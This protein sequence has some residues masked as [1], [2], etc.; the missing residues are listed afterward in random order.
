[1]LLQLDESLD[2]RHLGTFPLAFYAAQRWVEYAMYEDVASRFKVHI[3]QLFN[4]S[5]P[6]L[7]A[8]TWMHDVDSD[9]VRETIDALE[10]RPMRP[11]AA[12]LYYAVLC[13]FSGLANYLIITHG[14]DVNA[15]CGYHGSSLHAASYMGHLDYARLLLA[16]GTDVNTTNKR[17]KTP[18]GSAYDGGHLGA[19]RLLL[20]HGAD[21][22][23]YYD[24][25]SGL[26]S[27]EASFRRRADVVHLLLQH[28][29]DL[30]TRNISNETP[31]QAAFYCGLA[32]VAGRTSATTV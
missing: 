32:D 16:H 23:A 9:Q 12:A 27:Q 13:G 2:K 30:T 28:N 18:L 17:E 3:E 7:T 5:Q 29:A 4:P 31:L 10:E 25:A 21:V 8:W 1:V 15:K 24:R 22:D 11:K 26:L 20:E 6:Y 19:M 14:E